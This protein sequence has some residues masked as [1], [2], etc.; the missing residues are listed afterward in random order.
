MEHDEIAIIEEIKKGN[1][2]NFGKLY[3]IYVKPLYTYIYYKTHHKEIAEDLT[4]TTFFKALNNIHSFESGKSFRAW[5]YRIAHNNVIDYYRGK[6]IHQNIDDAWDIS[7]GTDF[8]GDLDS[9]R[10]LGEVKKY[11]KKLSK[12]QRD[13]IVMR[14]W[15]DLSYKEIAEIIGKSEGNCKVIFSRSMDKLRTIMPAT[16]YAAFILSLITYR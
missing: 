15:Q 1:R 16:L 3:D 14:V 6:K 5:L 8:V 10:K 2:E 13:I 11:L 4:S 12:E 7:D 9:D